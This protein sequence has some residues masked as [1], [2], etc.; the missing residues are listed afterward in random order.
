MS[1]DRPVVLLVADEHPDAVHEEF[2]ARYERDYRIELRPHAEAL[3]RARELVAHGDPLAMVAVEHSPAGEGCVGLLA[4]V[5]EIAPT[6]KRLGLVHASAY[7]ASVEQ[8]RVAMLGRHLDTF[9]GI[10]RGPRDEEFHTAIGEL[11]SDWTWTVAAPVSAAVDVVAEPEDRSLSAIR[12][13]LSR[14]GIPARYL[15]P[16][17]EDGA[18][19][20][21][22][23]GPGAPLPVVRH[24]GGRIL[25][26]ATPAAFSEAMYGGFEQIP[27]GEVADVAII[28]AGPAGL[29][30]PVYAASEG[31]DTVVLERDAI[32]GQAGSSSMIRNYL[33][34]P[35]G[36]SGMRLAQ[37]SRVQAGRFGAR[38]YT[39]RSVTRVAQ[40]PDDEPEH[41]HVELGDA[42]LCARTVVLAS[43]V[44]YRRLGVASV[45]DLVGAGVH[46]GAAIAVAREMQDRDVVVVGG[47]N[48]AGQA[49]VHLAKFARSVTIVVRRAGLAETMSHYLVTEIATTRNIAV[50]TRVVV[51]EGQGEGQLERLTLEGVDDG[52]HDT[53]AAD[54]LFC[55]LGAEPDTSW[56]PEPV[57]LDARGYVATG[58]DVP[59]GAWRDGLPPGSLETSMP[60]LF[61]VGDVR[62]GSMR[63]VASASGEGASAIPLVHAHLDHLREQQVAG[64]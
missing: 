16:A 60:G 14:T 8:L 26:G 17:S 41:L 62:S 61:A 13:L 33:G 53:V 6:A 31:L 3:A 9:V 36:V 54:A 39:G 47:G 18:A 55:M 1:D 4:E 23:A 63:R 49:A 50:R 7:A 45:E 27:D 10:P 20:V 28:G 46:Y 59:K 5:R 11:L 25:T 37:R 58:R 24:L 38:F 34:F 57:A 40:G 42:H 21:E 51:C 29:A 12:D 32:G 43:G 2:A 22:A 15:D 64:G 35:R 48:S 56:L 30:T 52:R 44:A 19:L